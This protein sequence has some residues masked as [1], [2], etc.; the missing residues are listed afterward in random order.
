MLFFCRDADFLAVFPASCPVGVLPYRFPSATQSFLPFSLR[1]V[2]GDCVSVWFRAV[3]QSFVTF[4]LRRVLFPSCCFL[5]R[6]DAEFLAVFPPSCPVSLLL[7][8][9]PSA[10]RSFGLFSLRRVLVECSA[11][12]FRAATLSFVPFFLRR[13]LVEC[14]VV[15]FRAATQSFLPFSLHRVLGDCVSVWFCSATQSFLPFPC[16]VS[17]FPPAVSSPVRDA[18]FR[19]VFFASCLGGVL[20]CVVPCRDVEFCSVFPASCPVWCS[21]V[22]FPVRD[23]EFR[24]V[25]LASCPGG[26]LCCV[27]PCHDA[28]FLAVFPASCPLLINA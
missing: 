24:A 22:P 14:S 28:E 12:W 15:W 8:P 10:T 1:R 13:V 25:F 4:F 17:C 9:L 26:V 19:A 11:V 18:E 20:C 27:V 5:S 2:L 21:A 3:T 7:F 23:A 6:R 16:V